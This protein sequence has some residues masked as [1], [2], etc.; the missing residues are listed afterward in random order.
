MSGMKKI[1]KSACENCQQTPC[2]NGQGVTIGNFA[3]GANL[4][5]MLGW[6]KITKSVSL[7]GY[8]SFT[9]SMEDGTEFPGCRL[10]PDFYAYNC[11]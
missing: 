10:T 11:S 8:P 6:S 2:L 3:S 9:G 4:T 1:K 7:D 5:P